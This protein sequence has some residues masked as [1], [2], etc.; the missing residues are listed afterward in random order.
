MLSASEM[1]KKYQQVKAEKNAKEQMEYQKRVENAI[2]FCE[3]DIAERLEWTLRDANLPR[4]IKIVR[5]M[6]MDE[7]GRECL[8]VDY[9]EDILA[10]LLTIVVRL[11]M[12]GY[13]VQYETRGKAIK[14]TIEY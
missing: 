14:L 13:D 6:T 7:Q 12:H 3:E 4:V 5:D 2:L 1:R 10:D 11:K 8:V 9:E